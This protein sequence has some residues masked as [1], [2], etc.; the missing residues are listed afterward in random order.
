MPNADG[1]WCLQDI[2]PICCCCARALSHQTGAPDEPI[3]RCNPSPNQNIRITNS[4]APS[5]QS[6]VPQGFQ[7]SELKSRSQEVLRK[8]PLRTSFQGVLCVW[9]EVEVR[10]FLRK[11]PQTL[12]CSGVIV[13]GAESLKPVSWRGRRVTNPRCRFIFVTLKINR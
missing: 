3:S 10:R 9:R 11:T 13:F 12:A 1:A 7:N 2:S 4:K 5:P 6:L 8:R